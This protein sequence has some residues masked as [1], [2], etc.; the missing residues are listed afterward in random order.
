MTEPRILSSLTEGLQNSNF[1]INGSKN[2]EI[3]IERI[4]DDKI[5]SADKVLEDDADFH[6]ESATLKMKFCIILKDF[7][8]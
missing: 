7:V 3:N 1:I 2:I 5:P 6:L 4:P 8:S